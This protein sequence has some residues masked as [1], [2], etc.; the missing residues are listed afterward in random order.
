MHCSTRNG[1]GGE[2]VFGKKF[3]DERPGLQLKHASEGV[4]A[5]G[6]SGKNANTSQFFI[7]L[8]PAPQCDGRHVVFGRVI[9]GLEV[10]RFIESEAGTPSGEPST[11]VAITAC[12]EW[13]A[14][15]DPGQGYWLDVPDAEAFSGTVPRF[16]ARQVAG[17]MQLLFLDLFSLSLVSWSALPCILSCL[18][19]EPGHMFGCRP[20]IALI[21]PNSSVA[22][23]LSETITSALSVNV[24]EGRGPVVH[25]LSDGSGQAGGANEVTDILNKALAD[26]G[27]DMVV[28]AEKCRGLAH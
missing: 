11:P 10:L 9:S 15:H 4:L 7:T 3:K 19:C 8:A 22:A 28:C 12:G 23:R 6:N 17:F 5:M 13:K 16:V 20:R 2:S 26:G 25:V 21:A 18:S 1:S 27:V 24:G 14:F